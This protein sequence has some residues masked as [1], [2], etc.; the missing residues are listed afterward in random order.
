[1]RQNAGKTKLAFSQGIECGILRSDF[2]PFNLNILLLGV[3]K[4][5]FTLRKLISVAIRNAEMCPQ[6]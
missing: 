1:M 2:N 6:I 3:P 5:N 4:K